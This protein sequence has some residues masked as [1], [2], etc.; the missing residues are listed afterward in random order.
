MGDI[1]S[2]LDLVLAPEVDGDALDRLLWDE[3]RRAPA[4]GRLGRTRRD[5]YPVR[6]L[7]PMDASETG[8]L[9]LVW[10]QV[11]PNESAAAAVLGERFGRLPDESFKG[12]D[13]DGL[14]EEAKVAYLAYLWEI[15]DVEETE[16]LVRRHFKVGRGRARAYVAENFEG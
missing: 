10:D 5:D 13:W 8:V 3:R 2:Y 9:R 16:R 15:G 4:G 11:T 12:P 14:N 6:Y 1:F 7:R